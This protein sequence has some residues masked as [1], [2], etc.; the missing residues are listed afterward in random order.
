MQAYNKLE[1]VFMS[2]LCFYHL[3]MYFYMFWCVLLC[4]IV[5]HFVAYC[6][7][8]YSNEVSY[9]LLTIDQKYLQILKNAVKLGSSLTPEIKQILKVFSWQNC[10]I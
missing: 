10:F 2:Y 5:K 6:E 7:K 3:Y 9:W 1:G 4:F 8:Y